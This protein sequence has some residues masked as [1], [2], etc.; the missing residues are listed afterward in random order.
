MENL[1]LAFLSECETVNLQSAPGIK[2]ARVESSGPLLGSFFCQHREIGKRNANAAKRPI[3]SSCPGKF[4]QS[5][6][7]SLAGV[8]TQA[9]A[10]AREI[11]HL[12]VLCRRDRRIPAH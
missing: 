9:W 2:R 3:E 1:V 7:Q 5:L 10:E 12:S 8:N 11:H 6:G 4:F